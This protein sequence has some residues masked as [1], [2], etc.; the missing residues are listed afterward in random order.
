[1]LQISRIPG[2]VSAF[3]L[4]A[5]K[6]KALADSATVQA[7]WADYNAKKDINSY[8]TIT[9]PFDGVITERNIHPGDLAGPGT[10]SSQPMLIL[11]QQSKLRLVVNIP[12]Q[13][14]TQ[15]SNAD[16]V[17]YQINALP[18]EDFTG[19]IARSSGSLSDNY[20]SE[21]I[22]LDVE[23]TPEHL[24]K[25]GMYAEV[26]LPINGNVNAFIV[27][28]SAVVTTTEH[29]Y[30]VAVENGQAKWIDVS[31]GDQSAD[32]TEVF[33]N[34]HNGSRLIANATYQVKNGQQIT[35]KGM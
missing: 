9:A 32:S 10:Q 19:K 11:Q 22:E 7:E 3:D 24:F 20:R 30:V 23:N 17:H 5:A 12:E 4:N 8:L 13:Y 16:V 35:Q 6:S 29:K 28:K 34:L 2:T 26:V 18:G 15:L 14:T 25:A 1:L 27:P 33:G 31:E 21:T